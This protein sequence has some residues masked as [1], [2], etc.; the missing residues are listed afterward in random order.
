MMSDFAMTIT[1]VMVMNEPSK[2]IEYDIL[3][4]VAGIHDQ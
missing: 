3:S 4:L 1:A 2:Y